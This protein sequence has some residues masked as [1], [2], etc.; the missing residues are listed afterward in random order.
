MVGLDVAPGG[1]DEHVVS[2][3]ELV[4]WRRVHSRFGALGL[5]ELVALIKLMRRIPWETWWRSGPPSLAGALRPET[6]SL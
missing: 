1:R 3:L 6:R 4:A 5:G 2:D